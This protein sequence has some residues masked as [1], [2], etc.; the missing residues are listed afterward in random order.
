MPSKN[1]VLPITA[2]IFHSAWCAEF[3]D[4]LARTRTAL[5]LKYMNTIAL[6]Q[7]DATLDPIDTAERRTEHKR[8]ARP[9]GGQ[10]AKRI[11]R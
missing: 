7:Y 6:N 5:G 9:A 3:M 8:P 1:L 10:W 11:P 4:A 2:P